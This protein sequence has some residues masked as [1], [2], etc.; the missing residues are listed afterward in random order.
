MYFLM[1]YNIIFFEKKVSVLIQTDSRLA[2]LILLRSK[3]SL[4]LTPVITT[5]LSEEMSLYQYFALRLMSLYNF[6]YVIKLLTLF[7]VVEIVH[8]K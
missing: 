5:K 8:G 3:S 6:E 2:L 4:Q 7:V 1:N